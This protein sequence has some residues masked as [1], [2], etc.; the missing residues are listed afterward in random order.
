M[1]VS[2]TKGLSSDEMYNLSMQVWIN[3]L[4][5]G[6]FPVHVN[7]FVSWFLSYHMSL[8]LCCCIIVCNIFLAVCRAKE[9][10]PNLSNLSSEI[11]LKSPPRIFV[12]VGDRKI[13]IS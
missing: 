6:C 13:K 4:F 3:V 10:P 5:F 1:S 9:F 12:S 7:F 11:H 2:V 8:W